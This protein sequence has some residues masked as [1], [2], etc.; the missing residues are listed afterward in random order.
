MCSSWAAKYEHFHPL[1]M[2]LYLHMYMVQLHITIIHNYVN[3]QI[4]SLLKRFAYMKS[5]QPSVPELTWESAVNVL[6]VNGMDVNRACYA[7]QCEW[8]QP[9]YE[10]IHSEHKKVK[11]EEM[12]EIK[13]IISKKDES[14]SKE[15]RR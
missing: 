9:V 7:V 8:L 15:V 11:Q 5:V 13:T 3:F 2:N 1:I 12:A 10:S 4:D 6:S 14:F